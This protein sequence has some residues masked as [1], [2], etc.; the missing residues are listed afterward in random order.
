MNAVIRSCCQYY[1]HSVVCSKQE[2]PPIPHGPSPKNTSFH[3]PQC[4]LIGMFSITVPGHPVKFY[5]LM[6]LSGI[7]C[8]KQGL[9]H[10]YLPR[11][12][13]KVH[14]F[15]STPVYI[16][17]PVLCHSPQ[18]SSQ[19]P[20]SNA[21]IRACTIGC[22]KQGLPYPDPHPHPKNIFPST[23]AYMDQPVLCHSPQA[24]SQIPHSNAVI[25]ACVQ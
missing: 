16:D 7:A 18:A 12:L 4:T 20:R 22:S 19:I 3:P 10:P 21:V 17:Q 11:P 1:M 15:P 5:T 24:S 14:V 13:P 23:P 2:I 6:Q 8:C 9:P 25:R